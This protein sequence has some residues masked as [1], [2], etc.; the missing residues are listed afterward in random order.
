MT[1]TFEQRVKAEGYVDTKTYRYVYTQFADH[2]E[3]QRIDINAIGT[4]AAIDSWETVKV[5]R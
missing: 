2:A 4:T 5:Y 1:K 3:I